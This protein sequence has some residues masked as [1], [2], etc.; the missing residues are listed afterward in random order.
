[1][2][3]WQELNDAPVVDARAILRA[4]CGSSRWVE[5]MIARR[6][7]GGREGLLSAAREEW[8]AL[9]APDWLEAFADH[10]AIGDRAALAA[11]FP[12]THHLSA[13]EQAGVGAAAVDVLTALA[14]AN[15]EYVGRFGFTFIVCATGKTADEMLRLLRDRLSNEREEELRVAA[16]EQA[17]I[18]AIRLTSP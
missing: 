14:D 7:F 6:P 10:P 4:C 2:E 8:F 16:E 1:M 12:A 3:R 11:R 17:K 15:R 18:T 5:R 9:S 13:H